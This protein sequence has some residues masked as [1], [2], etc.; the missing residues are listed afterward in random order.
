MKTLQFL[1]LALMLGFF[2]A[3]DDTSKSAENTENGE[4]TENT[5]PAAA[6]QYNIAEGGTVAWLGSKAE[7]FHHGSFNLTNGM[8]MVSENGIDGGDA[9]IDVAGIKV[10]DEGMDDETK[11]KLVGHL[12][13]EDFFNTEVYPEAEIEITGSKKYDGTGE[14]AP[15]TLPEAF[16]GYFVSDPTHII[17]AN[18]SVKGESHEITFPAKVSVTDGQLTAKAFITFDRRDY[19]LRFMS[20]TESTVNPEIHVGLDFM[21]AK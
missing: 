2:V 4:N 14:V 19:G 6:E 5:E 7:G 20:D 12:S 18:F 21:A 11:G 8:L 17:M 16:S 13:S 9:T 3:C 1:M 15:E 10:L